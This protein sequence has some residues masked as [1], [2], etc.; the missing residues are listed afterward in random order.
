L[1]DPRRPGVT[2]RLP[3]KGM[4]VVLKKTLRRTKPADLRVEQP[5]KFEMV[6]NFKTA[7]ATSLTIPQSV[8]IRADEVIR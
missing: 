3:S 4:M 1:P 6:I 7:T 2:R 8:I 5:T